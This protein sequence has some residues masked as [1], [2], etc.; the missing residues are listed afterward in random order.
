VPVT[1]QALRRQ[2]GEGYRELRF[3]RRD[4]MPNLKLALAV[5]P[6]ARLNIDEKDGL[7]LYPSPPP[8]AEK[9]LL[10]A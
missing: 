5:Y 8:V 10:R 1:W 9:K 4:V 7:I 2:F 3:F 6:E